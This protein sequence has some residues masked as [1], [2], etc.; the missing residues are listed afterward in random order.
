M[1]NDSEQPIKSPFSDAFDGCGVVVLME[2]RPLSDNYNQIML[3]E[4]QYKKALDLLESFMPHQTPTSFLVTTEDEDI[5]IKDA[6]EH[7]SEEEIKDE[8]ERWA[9]SNE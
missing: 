7:F 4:K 8:Q 1:K 6:R 2:T 9:D 3:T 5:I